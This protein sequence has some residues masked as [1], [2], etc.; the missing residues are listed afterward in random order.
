MIKARRKYKRLKTKLKITLCFMQIMTEFS[1]Q[2]ADVTY[3]DVV[4]DFYRQVSAFSNLDLYR[5]MPSS[6]FQSPVNQYFGELA[7]VTLIPLAICSVGAVVYAVQRKRLTRKGKSVDA[8][9]VQWLFYFFLFTYVVF[10]PCSTTVFKTFHCDYKFDDRGYL[11][12]DYTT[13]CGTAQYRFLCIYASA[14]LFVYPIGIPALYFIVLYRRHEDIDPVLASNKKARMNVSRDA[15]KE[16]V[17]LRCMD[18]TLEPLQFLFESYEPKYWWWEVL[19][20]AHRLIMT[21]ANIFLQVT[22][23]ILSCILL[24]IS[25]MAVK[26]YSYCDP[27]LL[28]SDDLFAEVSEWN[29][30]MF[31]IFNIVFQLNKPSFELGII[32]NIVLVSMVGALALVCLQTIS[33]EIKFFRAM[34]LAV[35]KAWSGKK[36]TTSKQ[37]LNEMTSIGDIVDQETSIGNGIEHEPEPY[38]DAVQQTCSL[39]CY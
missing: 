30:V 4:R 16:A 39:N 36:T 25:L 34:G 14:F 33:T 31:L 17:E 13:Q 24:A 12:A 18:R 7:A 32:C 9:N 37:G 1:T 21:S 19:I 23:S 38:D 29:I 2:F 35:S 26:L 10:V 28:D 22:P 15:V 6:C 5:L 3:P 8:L 11:F 20:C 27:Y